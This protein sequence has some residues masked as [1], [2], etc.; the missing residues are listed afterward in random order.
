MG[1]CP[2]LSSTTVCWVD[3][4]GL[5][6]SICS[7]LWPWQSSTAWKVLA[8]AAT[9][10]AARCPPCVCQPIRRRIRRVTS[11]VATDAA[12]ASGMAGTAPPPRQGPA[13]AGKRRR[14][15]GDPPPLPRQLGVSGRVWVTLVA[16]LHAII[17]WLRVRVARRRFRTVG[18]GGAAPGCRPRTGWLT[19]L[20][21]TIN[22]VLASRWTI[23]ILR[24]GTLVALVGFRRWRHLLT[25]LGSV[26]AVELAVYQLAIFQ[27]RPRPIGVG[28]SGAGTAFRSPRLR[29]R[30]WRSRWWAWPIRCCRPAGRAHWANG[31]RA[32]SLAAPRVRPDLPGPGPSHRCPGRGDRPGRGRSRWWPS[33]SSRPNEVFPVTYRRGKAAHLDVGG[34]R[35]QAIRTAVQQQLGLTVLDVQP[36]GLEGSAGSTPLRLRIAASRRPARARP[37]RQ[38]LRQEPRTRRPLLQARPHHP[39]RR[40]GGRGALPVGAPLR[41][42][43]GLHAAAAAPCGHPNARAIRDCGDHPGTRV[44]DRDGVLRR[45]PGDRHGRRSTTR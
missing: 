6:L 45:R 3:V 24:L 5:L 7:W 4:P 16:S 38:A 25:F 22:T 32:R 23:R 1:D 13:S 12:G 21:L 20:M 9:R 37:V 29:W 11:A 14:P 31:R 19:T 17:G 10:W 43:R 15:S 26:V 42:V 44:P 18:V 41:G 30:R 40:A 36:V 34:R 39:V 8:A 2:G 27:A 35:G 33:A 28:S